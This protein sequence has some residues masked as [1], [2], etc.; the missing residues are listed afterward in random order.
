ML[1]TAKRLKCIFFYDWV[2]MLFQISFSGGNIFLYLPV[3]GQDVTYLIKFGRGMP[4]FGNN[5]DV[6]VCIFIFI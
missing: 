5:K 6:F 4:P 2:K 1:N 3:F